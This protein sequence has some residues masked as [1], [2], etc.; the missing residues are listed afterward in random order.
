M[1]RQTR[2]LRPQTVAKS[3]LC[4]NAGGMGTLFAVIRTFKGD[5][6]VR[7]GRNFNRRRLLHVSCQISLKISPFRSGKTTVAQALKLVFASRS[8]LIHQDSYFLPDERIAIDPATGMKNW[9][10]LEAVDMDA[11]LTDLRALKADSD[12]KTHTR[13]DCHH[14]Q[15]SGVEELASQFTDIAE[16]IKLDR[17]LIVDGFLLYSD[18]RVLNELT[19]P[20]DL[21][22]IDLETMCARRSNRSYSIQSEDFGDEIPWKDPPNYVR[23]IAHPEYL[24]YHAKWLQD[25]QQ[26]KRDRIQIISS[27]KFD[28]QEILKRCVEDIKLQTSR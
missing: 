4:R 19:G 24:R 25:E 5:E 3:I 27:L 10:R 23:D 18:E 12:W 17:L 28:P 14:T 21:L 15:V 8:Q 9:D 22:D 2:K 7:F 6:Y 26:A 20:R 16:N 13:P 1:S 11:F